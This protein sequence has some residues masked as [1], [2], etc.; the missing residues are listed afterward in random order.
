MR[1]KDGLKHIEDAIKKLSKRHDEHIAVYDPHGGKCTLKFKK[2]RVFIT[3]SLNH[4]VFLL[5]QDNQRRL[6]GKH[7]TAS[8][9]VFT[10]GV[11]DR[12]SSVR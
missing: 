6:D 12:N 4:D 10:W 1:R 9:K 7:E 5:G 2:I 3:V 11:G 8:F